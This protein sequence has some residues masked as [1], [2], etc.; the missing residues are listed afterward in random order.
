MDNPSWRNHRRSYSDQ[1]TPTRCRWARRY[2]VHRGRSR[3]GR[4]RR[5]RR[6]A[7]APQANMPRRSRGTRDSS[8]SRMRRT[9]SR[10]RRGC[11]CRRTEARRCRS[12]RHTSR[13][14][15]RCG[16]HSFE[17]WSWWLRLSCCRCRPGRCHR[18][19]SSRRTHTTRTR[20]AAPSCIRRCALSSPLASTALGAT[21]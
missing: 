11:T 1:H 9:P 10:A 13:R 4:N 20:K 5:G 3:P 15:N 6:I 14:G 18:P 8:T 21:T 19:R 2:P 7:R 17:S 12:K 16:C